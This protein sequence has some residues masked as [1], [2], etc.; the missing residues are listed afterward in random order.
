MTA[1]KRVNTCIIFLEKVLFVKRF[2]LK[3]KF[4]L[5]KIKFNPLL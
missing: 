4:E 2:N 5:C 3:I 1:I